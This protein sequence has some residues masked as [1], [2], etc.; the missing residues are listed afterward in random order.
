MGFDLDNPA[1]M[2]TAQ[3]IEGATNMPTGRYMMKRMNMKEVVDTSNQWWQR[4]FAFGGWAPWDLGSETEADM[5]KSGRKK[6]KKKK[7]KYYISP[8]Y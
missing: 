4:T 8:S 3:I 5:Y 2:G 1:F 6:K 7:P